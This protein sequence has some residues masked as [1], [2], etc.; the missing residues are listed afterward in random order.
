MALAVQV[1]YVSL[2]LVPVVEA[3]RRAVEPDPKTSGNG[4]VM[5]LLS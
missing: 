4:D 5:D 2:V 3:R 1:V